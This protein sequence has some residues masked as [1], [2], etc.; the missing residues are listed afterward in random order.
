M[1]MENRF[2]E[3]EKKRITKEKLTYEDFKFIVL[4]NDEVAFIYK[5]FE[6]EIVHDTKVQVYRNTYQ[7]TKIVLSECVGEFESAEEFLRIFKI[8]SMTIKDVWKDA[9]FNSYYN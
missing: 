5:D 8:G 3:I 2:K 4:S 9:K 7:G 6:Y 1:L